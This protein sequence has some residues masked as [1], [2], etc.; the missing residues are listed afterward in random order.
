MD[1]TVVSPL[2]TDRL[3][4][5]IRTPGHT[6]VVAFNDKCRDYSEACKREGISLIPLSVESLGSWHKKV[7]GQ[8]RKL[9]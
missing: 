6:L 1:V 3:D 8:L 5:S 4:N 9:A 7:V 2:L